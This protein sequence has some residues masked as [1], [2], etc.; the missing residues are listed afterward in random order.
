MRTMIRTLVLAA[1]VSTVAACAPKGPTPDAM[2]AAANEVDQAFLNGFNAGDA[3]ALMATYWNSPELVN[4]GLDGMGDTGWGGAKAGWEAVFAS[5]P[6]AQLAFNDPHNIAQGDVVLGWGGWTMTI[7]T[8]DGTGMVL[9]GRYS[10]VKAMRDG[11]WVY[12]M[13]HAS[14]PMPPAPQTP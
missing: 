9:Q 12:I 8:G 13:D 7:P 11:K 4:I 5:M 10:D 1:A 2:V 3:N 6:G 14:V